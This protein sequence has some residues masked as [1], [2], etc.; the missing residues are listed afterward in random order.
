M[1]ASPGALVPVALEAVALAGDLIRSRRPG[2]L[3]AKGDRDMASELDFAVERAVRARLRLRTPE[4]AVLGEEEES[5]DATTAICCGR[6][7]RSTAPPTS[8]TACR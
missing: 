5:P 6:S 3:T 7:T 2:T 8:C 4:V 1:T